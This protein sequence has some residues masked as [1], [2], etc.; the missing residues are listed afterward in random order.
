MEVHTHTHTARK[1]WTHYFWEFLMLFL[2]VFCGFL[3]ENQREHM[4]E[5]NRE[6]QYMITMLEDLKADIP[7]LDSTIKNFEIVNT[8]ID[9]VTQAISFPFNNI[10]FPTIYR[11]L[12]A[13][14]NYWSF[15]YNDRTITQLKN[16]GGFRLI[17]NKKVANKIIAYDQF[18]NDAIPNITKLNGQFYLNTIALRSK[19]FS[20]GIMSELFK[21]YG[22]NVALSSVDPWIDSLMKKNVVPLK[23]E[24]QLILLFEFRNS[25]IAQKRDYEGNVLW[26]YTQTRQK[27]QE[28]IKLIQVEYHLK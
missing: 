2:A 1:K 3:A 9:T 18:N 14:F 26:G 27:I 24:N 22:N 20:E 8:S 28:L 4:I 12:N 6:K 10:S 5:H 7:L 11:H 21:L 13:S 16:S 25:L 15:R 23:P 19:I 17:R